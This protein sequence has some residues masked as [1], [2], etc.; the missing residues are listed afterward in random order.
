MT[1]KIGLLSKP[2]TL[3]ILSFR[4]PTANWVNA[5]VNR[6]LIVRP[7]ETGDYEPVAVESIPTY[8][9]GGITDVVEGGETL[10]K[11]CWKIRDDIFWGDGT[12]LT[13][14]DYKFTYEISQDPRSN[15][16]DMEANAAIAR[17]EVDP[18]D[19]RTFAIFYRNR[20]WN[21][22]Q[23]IGRAMPAHLEGPV[24]DD[25]CRTGKRYDAETLYKT[26]PTTPG[27]YC[28]PFMVVHYEADHML[29][30]KN[31]Y[32]NGHVENEQLEVRFLAGPTDPRLL[33]VD[34]VGS[35]G[36]VHANLDVIAQQLKDTHDVH[37]RHG[38]WVHQLAFNTQEGPCSDKRVRQT[39]AHVLGRM[40]L[41][42]LTTGPLGARC[43]SLMS[44]KL[45]EYIDDGKPSLKP[46]PAVFDALE[47]PFHF[48]SNPRAHRMFDELDAA[49]RPFG[50]LLKKHAHS[51][52]KYF[53]ELRSGL[54]TGAYLF[55]SAVTREPF[56]EEWFGAGSIA[57]PAQ[58]NQGENWSKWSRPELTECVD[59][60]L[61]E[62]DF[63]SRLR[64]YAKFKKLFA[65]DVPAIPLA[66]GPHATLAKKGMVGISPPIGPYHESVA[67][68]TWK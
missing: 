24:W 62:F 50:I 44:R 13:G 38:Y 6:S 14:F 40:D 30:Q 22:H 58:G 11:T 66:Y 55:S 20:A 34:I 42:E 35:P 39:I 27:L 29:L 1:L 33:D 9:N 2:D 56:L 61:R 26:S 41:V 59:A 64:S 18:S 19:S 28:G 5:A 12:P 45:S 25:C 3:N 43:N 49:L 52:G 54:L 32:W 47:V 51:S 31:P 21:F 63:D 65:E 36:V 15:P 37:V 4:I 23:R 46:L 10:M 16:T 48:L 53:F 68:E 60:W 57:D 17:I 67:I 8:F 7:T